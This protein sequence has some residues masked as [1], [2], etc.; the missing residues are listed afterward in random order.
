MLR[1][2]PPWLLTRHLKN[3]LA[4]TL[5]ETE[6]AFNQGFIAMSGSHCHGHPDGFFCCH[7]HYHGSLVANTMAMTTR[8]RNRRL[9]DHENHW[10]SAAKT[11][12]FYFLA[13]RW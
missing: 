12:P 6:K 2:I 3:S 11:S 4:E 10:A 8:E 1:R 13:S 9:R 7:Y 5:T